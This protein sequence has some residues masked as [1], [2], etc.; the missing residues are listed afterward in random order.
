MPTVLF[1]RKA[2]DVLSHCD[3]ETNLRPIEFNM[4]SSMTFK[5][6]AGVGGKTLQTKGPLII[7]L[8]H[9]NYRSVS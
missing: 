9:V 5:K 7:Q 4:K 6:L 3:N 2:I 1:T 8:S